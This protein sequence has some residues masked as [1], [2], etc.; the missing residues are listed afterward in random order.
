MRALKNGGV[1]LGIVHI[2]RHI[3]D[4]T[5][6]ILRS[7][8]VKESPAVGVGIDVRHGVLFEFVHVGLDPFDGTQQAGLFGIPRAINNGALRIPA[9]A[10]QF[11]QHASFFQHGGLAG[12]RIVGAV[13]PRVVMIAAN[14]PLAV[15]GAAQGG[16]DVVNGLDVPVRSNFQM[17]FRGAGPD[18]ISD[19]QAATPVFRRHGPL[20]ADSSG[21]ASE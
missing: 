14:D 12:N 11:A 16:D 4:K 20:R 5:F 8:R 19:G 1:R 6:Q 2:A 18:V 21:S 13:H 9:L 15:V 3:A 17:H 10:M 7:A